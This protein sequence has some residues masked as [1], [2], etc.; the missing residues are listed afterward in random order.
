MK[1]WEVLKTAFPDVITTKF[2]FMDYKETD[3]S[4]EYLLDE[5]EYMSREDYKKG[6]VRPYG[7]TDSMTIQ[8]C[9]IR[10]LSVY[11]H[12]RRRKW[13]D[14]SSGEILSYTYDNLSEDGS[15][16]SPKLVSFLKE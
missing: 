2:E 16:L 1:Q 7:F 10:G 14:R 3:T 13:I 5:R 15:K 4:L 11:L 6:C 9:P 8:D 12:V